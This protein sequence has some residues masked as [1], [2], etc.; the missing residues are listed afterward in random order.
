VY[1][2]AIKDGKVVHVCNCYMYVCTHV[3]MVPSHGAN[4]IEIKGSDANNKGWN[5][6][7]RMCM[8]KKILW[9]GVCL[10]KLPVHK[11]CTEWW[12]WLF[13]LGPR[14][15]V[16]TNTLSVSLILFI[17]VYM[18]YMV[19]TCRICMYIHVY[20]KINGVICKYIRHERCNMYVH[21]YIWFLY[22]YLY[23]SVYI[24]MCIYKLI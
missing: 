17:C 9:F 3:A 6:Y 15:C 4:G 22:T 5:F 2:G 13:F 24:H 11:C 12:D 8:Y 14:T 10:S 23:A 7:Q 18:Y 16:P 21:V 19:H 20:I 1:V